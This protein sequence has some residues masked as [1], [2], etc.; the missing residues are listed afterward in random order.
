MTEL[1]S[2]LEHLVRRHPAGTILFREGE[3]GSTMYV[4]RSGKARISKLISDTELTLARRVLQ[5]RLAEAR[6][7]SRQLDDGYSTS[8]ALKQRFEYDEA[9]RA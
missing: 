7:H 6:E 5:A 3:R 4:L 8:L 9:D 2:S 1:L